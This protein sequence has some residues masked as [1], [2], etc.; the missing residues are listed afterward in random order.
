MLCLTGLT[1][2]CSSAIIDDIMTSRDSGKASVAYFY[3]DFR[4]THKQRRRNLL[5]SLLIQLSARSDTCCDILACL[6]SENDRGVHKPSDRAMTKCLKDM[7]SHPEQCPTYIIM[8][9]L[10]E[11]PNTSGIPSPREEVLELVDELA[12][13]QL[14]N[15]HIC[16]TSRPEIDI[17]AVLRPLCSRPISLHDESGQK[18]DIVDYV[19]SV[20]HSD[21]RMRRWREE[22]KDLVIE[23]LAEKADGM[24]VRHRILINGFL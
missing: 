12:G 18:Q 23:T 19:R 7:L 14:P 11:C 1:S 20:V 13:L 10:D 2:L 24:C 6:Y 5:P 17:Q 22:D 9:A 16:V 8:D 15:L 4:D 3:F 21:K